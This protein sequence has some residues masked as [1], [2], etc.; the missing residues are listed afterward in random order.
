MNHDVI[1]VGSQS[2]CIM[3]IH[4]YIYIY[5][6]IEYS[7]MNQQCYFRSIYKPSDVCTGV[8]DGHR[9]MN[10]SYQLST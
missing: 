7:I 3:C 8:N 6:Y 4:I 9:I 10:T 5:I 1:Q 2:N